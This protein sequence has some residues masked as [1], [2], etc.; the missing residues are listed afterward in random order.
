MLIRSE[1]NFG[2]LKN[3]QYVITSRVLLFTVTGI[4]SLLLWTCNAPPTS[5]ETASPDLVIYCENGILGPIKE[6]TNLFEKQSGLNIDIQNDCARNLTSLI[7]YRREADIFIPDTRQAIDNILLSDPKMIADSAFLGFQTLVF[8]VPKN[9]PSLFDGQLTTLPSPDQAIIL[10]NPESSTLGLVTGRLLQN[11]GLY[12]QVM[13]SI[14][15]LTTDS[16]GL[17]RNLVSGQA[18][19]AI[20]WRSDYLSNH[21]RMKIDTLSIASNDK[22]FEAMA[23]IL[24]DAPNSQNAKIF[25]NLLKS[26][27]S[28]KLLKKY[29]ID[30]FRISH[31]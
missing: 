26:R 13:N 5:G 10:A 23:V 18:S 22:Y 8:M 27:T 16:R 31:F 30:D 21:A 28:K 25:L 1:K 7:H 2:T 4:I 11:H 29:G 17:I 12:D 6:I 3:D 24:R 9:N 14:V 19:V 15:L 20:G